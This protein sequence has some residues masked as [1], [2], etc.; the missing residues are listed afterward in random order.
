[1]LETGEALRKAATEALRKAVAAAKDVEPAAA[2]ARVQ[3]ATNFFFAELGR[4]RTIFG[5]AK[6][7]R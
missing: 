7:M 1:M 5:P 6:A 3:A 2:R 4:I